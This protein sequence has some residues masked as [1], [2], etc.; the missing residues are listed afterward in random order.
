MW[1]KVMSTYLYDVSMSCSSSGNVKNHAATFICV[2]KEQ[3]IEATAIESRHYVREH[4]LD[5]ASIEIKPPKH[6]V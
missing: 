6:L 4:H 2:Y 1:L 5:S 3:Q